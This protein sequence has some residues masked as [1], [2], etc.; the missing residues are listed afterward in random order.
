M[1]GHNKIGRVV[2]VK[3]GVLLAELGYCGANHME[4]LGKWNGIHVFFG[5]F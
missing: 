1:R 3:T 2:M 4:G 5:M